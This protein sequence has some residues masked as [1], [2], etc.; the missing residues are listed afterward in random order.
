MKR[1]FQL[2]Q[3]K[4][5]SIR[6]K[7]EASTWRKFK[8]AKNLQL[9]K[10]VQF[11]IDHSVRGFKA[12][13]TGLFPLVKDRETINRRLDRI[14][15]NGKERRYCS[16]FT[17]EEKEAV[18]KYVKNRNRSLQGINKT[19]LTKLLDILR[20]RDYMNK[21]CKGGRKLIKLSPNAKSALVN[22]KLSRSFWTRFHAKHSSLT[23]K[24]QGQVLINRALN[25]TR[26]M[27][28]NH[29][30]DLA[31]E[32]QAAGIMKNAKKVDEGVWKGDIDTT[33]IFND[34]ETPEFVNY[35]VDGTSTGLV[36][37]GKGDVCISSNFFLGWNNKPDDTTSS[38]RKNQS[39]PCYNI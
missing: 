27:A 8:D 9:E 38:C 15:K 32:L 28:C 31:M 20:I 24:R 34:D 17:L 1:K 12:L 22:G 30:N 37:A 23:I 39:P 29:L 33:R 19:E 11:C 36:Y 3:E 25:C 35:G 13:K 2:R 10:A 7:P 14:I 6:G 26:E 21:R 18:V 5:Q 4:L 16:L